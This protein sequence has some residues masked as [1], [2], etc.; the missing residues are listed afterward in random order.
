MKK[1]EQ[2]IFLLI[3]IVLSMLWGIYETKTVDVSY[4]VYP[5][6]FVFFS[7]ALIVRIFVQEDNK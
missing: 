7:I 1:R 3:G 2:C 5:I 6:L 4:W